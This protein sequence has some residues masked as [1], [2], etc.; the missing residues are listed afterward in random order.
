M[1]RGGFP[2][3]AGQSES[4]S[5]LLC[6]VS[7]NGRLLRSWKRGLDQLITEQLQWQNLSACAEEL[8]KTLFA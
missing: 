3:C 6:F 1:D 2:K 4:S 8:Y 7:T 5:E